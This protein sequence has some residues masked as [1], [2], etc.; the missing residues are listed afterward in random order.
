MSYIAELLK[1]ASSTVNAVLG[2]LCV[3]TNR[4]GDEREIRAVIDRNIQVFNDYGVLAGYRVEAAICKDE[5]EELL[6]G[7][8]L[9]DEQGRSYRIDGITKE[10]T[11]KFYVSL[12]VE[13]VNL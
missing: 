2:D 5:V 8:K 4:D 13:D 7:D 12:V 3:Y 6:I 1:D 10:T 9:S 11:A